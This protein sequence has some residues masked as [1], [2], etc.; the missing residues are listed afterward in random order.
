MSKAR[1][2]NKVKE[3]LSI[4]SGARCA[5]C[6]IYLKEDFLTK[7]PA[8]FRE[9]AHI[10][11]D[12]D[13]GPRG[14]PGTLDKENVHN[15]I[16]LCPTCHKIVDD[17]PT[18]Y[19]ID[20][21]IDMKKNHEER[22]KYLTSLTYDK[23]VIHVV[24]HSKIGVKSILFQKQ[25]LI[26]A[27]LEE[28]KYPDNTVL[29]D[30]SVQTSIG[31]NEE[32]YYKEATREIDTLFALYESTIMSNA[33]HLFALA[34]QPLLI[35]LGTKLQSVSDVTVRQRSRENNSWS[36][37][38]KNSSIDFQIVEPSKISR[39]NQVAL[40]I[41]VSDNVQEERISSIL[42][43]VDIWYV[44]CDNPNMNIIKNADMIE[45]FKESAMKCFS[46]IKDIYGNH[47]PIHVFPA[48]PNSLSVEFGRVW[49]PKINNSLILYD[50][51]LNGEHKVFKQ[52]LIIK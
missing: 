39:N 34:P 52:V 40:I 27:I 14:I 42:S 50:Q 43:G 29:L 35:Y 12:S 3:E 17:D 8:E 6:N 45:K 32:S 21:L 37:F 47:S 7:N 46:I 10:I 9:C 48:M 28:E 18:T 26:K 15:I 33:T 36:W 30:L 24:F 49:M 20:Y 23:R 44:K 22:I 4:L 1:I 2:K 19:H 41:S 11:A 13:D 51:I 16:I 5:K 31:D 38:D 25:Q